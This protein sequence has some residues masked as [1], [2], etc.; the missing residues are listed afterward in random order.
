MGTVTL[1]R[2]QADLA[3]DDI[4]GVCYGVEAT[5]RGQNARVQ[6]RSVRRRHYVE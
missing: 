1:H 2:L 5:K 6:D 4:V 3:V